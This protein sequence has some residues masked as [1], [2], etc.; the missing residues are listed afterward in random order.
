MVTRKNYIPG[1]TPAGDP[2]DIYGGTEI[3]YTV[4]GYGDLYAHQAGDVQGYAYRYVGGSW[5]AWGLWSRA[6]GRMT[7][8][9]PATA[10]T[11]PLTDRD[12]RL[13]DAA[14]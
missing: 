4:D 6:A 2:E 3:T 13:L 12:R 1:P 7:G 14:R 8:E 10:V 11:T 9:I 5:R